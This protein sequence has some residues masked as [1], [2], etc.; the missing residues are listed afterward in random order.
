MTDHSRKAAWMQAALLIAALAVL[1]IVLVARLQ[2]PFD[3]DTLAI[4][5]GQLQSQSAEAALLARHA[6]SDRLAPGF[7]RQHVRQ[8]ADAVARVQGALQSKPAQPALATDLALARQSGAALH[9]TLQ[10]WSIDASRASG[11]MT[12]FDG[13]A[14]RMDTLDK[15]LKPGT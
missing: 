15:Q 1:G 3:R 10:A 4:Q 5:V 9:A 14:L 7:T 2:R 8:L 13:L 6:V 11:A 12:E